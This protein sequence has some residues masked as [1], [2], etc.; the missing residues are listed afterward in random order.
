MGGVL[1]DGP[2]FGGKH[3]NT[4]LP[5]LSANNLVGT[6]ASSIGDLKKLQELD[7][8]GNSLYGTLPSSIGGLDQ[9]QTLNFS[10]NLLCFSWC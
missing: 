4:Q 8:S 1:C 7:F 2:R 6:L 5:G 10:G 3:H 9:L